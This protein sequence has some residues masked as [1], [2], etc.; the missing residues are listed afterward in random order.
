MPS[1]QVQ[2]S[3][4]GPGTG[5]IGSSL[6]NATASAERAACLTLSFFI[7][8]KLIVKCKGEAC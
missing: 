5:Q 7:L 2:D 4:V 1:G 8:G 3:G 6:S